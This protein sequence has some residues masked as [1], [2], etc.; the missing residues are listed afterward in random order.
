MTHDE[1]TASPDN[2]QAAEPESESNATERHWQ[3]DDIGKLR[4]YAAKQFVREVPSA[5]GVLRA[6]RKAIKNAKKSDVEY[7]PF[8]RKRVLQQKAL[9]VGFQVIGGKIGRLVVWR[10]LVH[11]Y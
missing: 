8:D 1:D 2:R 11:G 3:W 7:D 6:A 5:R 9:A 10:R 4:A